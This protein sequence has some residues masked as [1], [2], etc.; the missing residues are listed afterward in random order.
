[1]TAGQKQLIRDLMFSPLCMRLSRRERAEVERIT[2]LPENAVLGVELAGWL[3]K[4][5][6]AGET[7]DAKRKAIT[8]KG[9]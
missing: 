7:D 9:F 2:H 5:V 1:M 6:R 4:G 8:R 3:G